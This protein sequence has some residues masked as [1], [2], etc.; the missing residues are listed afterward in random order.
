MT[1]TTQEH[2]TMT[3]Y[4]QATQE[5]RHA[6]ADLKGFTVSVMKA[7]DDQADPATGLTSLFDEAAEEAKFLGT[8]AAERAAQW[9]ISRG[10]SA[11]EAT[12]IVGVAEKFMLAQSTGIDPTTTDRVLD[13][14]MGDE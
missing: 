2:T 12:R 14:P 8:D 13:T 6:S 3:H 4:Y 10:C 11:H 5:G 1:T 9:L 7:G